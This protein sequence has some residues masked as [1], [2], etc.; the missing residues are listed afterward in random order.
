VL[1][2]FHLLK[3]KQ[4]VVRIG[5]GELPLLP[6]SLSTYARDFILK[7]LQVDPNKR[8]TAAQLLD[9]PFINTLSKPTIIENLDWPPIFTEQCYFFYNGLF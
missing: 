2:T 6:D 7:C 8:P 5:R 4:A 3:Q 1:N 9:H